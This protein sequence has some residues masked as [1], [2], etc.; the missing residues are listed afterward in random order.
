M[1]WMIELQISPHSLEKP[2]LW[3]ERLTAKQRALEECLANLQA[4]ETKFADAQQEH[5]TCLT[6]IKV[7]VVVFKLFIIV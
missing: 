5:E 3:P 7:F 1:E 2:M 4:L 6:E